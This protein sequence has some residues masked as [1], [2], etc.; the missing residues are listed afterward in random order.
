[1]AA[2]SLI[3]DYLGRGLLAARP[4][5][6]NISASG[7][8]IYWAEDTNQVFCWTGSSWRD[9]TTGAQGPQGPTEW[10]T[11]VLGADFTT[12]ANTFSSSGLAFAPAASTRYEFE[13][14]LLLRTNTATVGPRPGVSWPTGLT[15]G[16]CTVRMPTAANAEQVAFGNVNA[17]V[18]AAAGGLPNT[19]QSWP[20]EI[21]GTFLAGATP[22]GNLA[23]QLA[24]ETA[25]TQVALK[26]GSLL[27]YRVVP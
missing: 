17:A 5:S 4:T 12:T 21:T 15:D 24:S 14:K 8:A 7:T 11:V 26:A 27:R 22:V 25:G 10:T 9:M 23:V 20:A 2:S 19:T 16:V 18:Q 1:M 3:I 6:P 13:S